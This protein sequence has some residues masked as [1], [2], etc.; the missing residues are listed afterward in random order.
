[1]ILGPFVR[2]L[3][4]RRDTDALVCKG[5]SDTQGLVNAAATVGLLL[6]PKL[7]PKEEYVN[8]IG[9]VLNPYVQRV[10]PCDE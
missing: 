7:F 9:L 5:N 2:I 10:T 3:R 6:L 8:Q 1:M 4:F